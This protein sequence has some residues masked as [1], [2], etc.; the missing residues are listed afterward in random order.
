MG[1]TRTTKHLPAVPALIQFPDFSLCVL[2][3]RLNP[4]SGEWEAGEGGQVFPAQAPAGS[5]SA[6]NWDCLGLFSLSSSCC[7]S[8]FNAKLLNHGKLTS[9]KW[10]KPNSLILISEGAP[11]HGGKPRW[12]EVLVSRSSSPEW[13]R[14]NTKKMGGM[15]HLPVWKGEDWGCSACRMLWTG[16]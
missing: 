7:M 1:S 10:N 5:G 13:Q 14:W 12:F 16:P 4:S 3:P 9:S 15:E 11:P 6:G 8:H 2:D